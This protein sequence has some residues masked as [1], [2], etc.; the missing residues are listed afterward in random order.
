METN[1]FF[2]IAKEIE[3][4]SF[5]VKAI[6]LKNDDKYLI[7]VLKITINNSESRSRKLKNYDS[8]IFYEETFPIAELEQ[9]RNNILNKE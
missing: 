4:S 1:S 9:F 8:V 7:T 3:K 6:L 5:N 2:K